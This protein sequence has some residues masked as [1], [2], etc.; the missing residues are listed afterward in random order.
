MS[1]P[2]PTKR[3]RNSM[4]EFND[5]LKEKLAKFEKRKGMSRYSFHGAKISNEA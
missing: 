3:R 5:L 2:K 1:R 4:A